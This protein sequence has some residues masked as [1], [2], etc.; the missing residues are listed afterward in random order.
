[1]DLAIVRLGK[2]MEEQE[3]PTQYQEQDFLTL[4][5]LLRREYKMANYQEQILWK[6]TIWKIHKLIQWECQ[7]KCVS[8]L[9]D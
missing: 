2:Q 4:K 1:M 5:N 9:L 6:D 3:Q 8:F 7:E